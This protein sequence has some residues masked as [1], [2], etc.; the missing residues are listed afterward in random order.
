[1]AGEEP[2]AQTADTLAPGFYWISVDGLPPEVARRDAE[3]GEWVLT[4]VESSIADGHAAEVVVLRGPLA[5]PT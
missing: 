4:G 3:A 1:M 2:V 5:V